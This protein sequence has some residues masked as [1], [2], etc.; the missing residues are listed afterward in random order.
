M[1]SHSSETASQPLMS[2]SPTLGNVHSHTHD[3]VSGNSQSFN[4]VAEESPLEEEE[5]PQNPA[6]EEIPQ[7]PDSTYVDEDAKGGLDKD[8]FFSVRLTPLID[9]SSTSSGLYFSPIIRR[10][11][12]KHPSTS[13]DTLKRTKRQHTH[14]RDLQHRLFSKVKSYHVHMHCFSVMKMVSGF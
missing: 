2:N 5:E 9:H 6:P 14:P 11:S 8:G 4:E 3:D 12:P 7:P 1:R 10:L 13:G